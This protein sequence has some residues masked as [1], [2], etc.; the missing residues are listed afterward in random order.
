MITRWLLALTLALTALIVST[1]DAHAGKTWCVSAFEPG[2]GYNGGSGATTERDPCSD[3]CFGGSSW[4]FHAFLNKGGAC[5][6]CWD[7]SDNTCQDLAKDEGY[8]FISFSSCEGASIASYSNDDQGCVPDPAT[9]PQPQPQPQADPGN[10][11]PPVAVPDVA[12]AKKPLPIPP[13]PRPTDYEGVIVKVGPGPYAVNTPIAMTGGATVAGEPKKIRRVVAGDF[14]VLGPDGAEVARFHGKPKGRN[15]IAQ[16]SI[17]VGGAVTIRFEPKNIV[18]ASSEKLATITPA[19]QPLTVAGCRVQAALDGP[20]VGEILVADAIAPLRGH[21]VDAA[22]QPA[23]PAALN[24]AKAIFVVEIA[25]EEQRLDATLDAA[26]L[27]TAAVM[28]KKP[29]ADVEVVHVRLIADGGQND[30]CPSADVE[31]KT[32]ALGVGIDITPDP[33]A[34]GKPRQC[35]VDR[36]C[37][38]TARFRLPADPTAR[39]VGVRFVTSPGLALTS[40][41]G[42]AGAA[43]TADHPGSVDAIWKGTV[44]PG[45]AGDVSL[46]VNAKSSA[47]EVTDQTSI[48]VKEPIEL[49]LAPTLDLGTVAAGSP[50]NAHCVDLSFKTSRGVLYQRFHLTATRPSGCAS[51]PTIFDAS[52]GVG[53][54]LYGGG[55]TVEIG[56]GLSVRLCLAKIPR[57]AAESPKPA[58]LTV[59]AVADDFPEQHVEVAVSW[60]VSGRSLLACW[61]WLIAIVGG[62]LFV[63]VVGYGFVR[64]WRFAVDDQVQLA[65]KREQLARAVGR[66]L[67]DLP[68]GRTGWYRSAAVGLLDN[69][70]AT[71]KLGT[72]LVELHARRGEVIIKCRGGLERVSP[73]SKKLEPVAEAATKDG[74]VASKNVVYSAG[75]LFFQLK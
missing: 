74:H 6:S 66:R 2:P 31:A 19:Q 40:S 23:A 16:V 17:P 55:A 32:T 27:A 71:A 45:D 72:A 60:Q 46:V 30:V 49:H 13:K 58:I 48:D 75:S 34:D 38:V 29:Q 62:T 73:Q 65:G 15:V 28:I 68:G 18:T 43:L 3:R 24:G 61:W 54:A 52:K 9:Q 42:G 59:A 64:P 20:T 67:R 39:T 21:F 5:F 37:P 4:H 69:G 63:V 22:G 56:D 25:G 8:A 36:P 35:Y 53:A 11:A 41:A 57:C 47:G 51:F 26:G 7:E 12:P 10:T 1:G 44:I 33:R 14:V 50:A 70:Q